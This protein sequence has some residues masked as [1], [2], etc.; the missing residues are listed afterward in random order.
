MKWSNKYNENCEYVL[1]VRIWFSPAMASKLKEF[2]MSISFSISGNAY[3][4]FNNMSMNDQDSLLIF[5]NFYFY[6]RNANSA[7][8]KGWF[9]WKNITHS[10]KKNVPTFNVLYDWIHCKKIGICWNF[11]VVI[12]PLSAL[13]IHF[14]AIKWYSQISVKEWMACLG[15]FFVVYH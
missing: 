14:L 15:L 5:F 2:V 1:L 7:H 11:F 4:V 12:R 9:A 6:F 13:Y 8:L 3:I 10:P